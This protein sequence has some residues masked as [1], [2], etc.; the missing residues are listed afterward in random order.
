MRINMI[1]LL[2]MALSLGACKDDKESDPG[3]SEPAVDPAELAQKQLDAVAVKAIAN[4]EANGRLFIDT[5]V[6]L[7]CRSGRSIRDGVFADI[8]FD[9]E[10]GARKNYCYNVSDDRKRLGLS[11]GSEMTDEPWCLLLDGSGEEVLREGPSERACI[12]ED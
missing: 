10:E 5:G 4:F 9:P 11:F 7:Y 2:A 12:P 6:A 8:G 1:L 3:P